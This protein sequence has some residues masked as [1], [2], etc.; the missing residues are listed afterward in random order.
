MGVHAWGRKV[1]SFPPTY[2]GEEGMSLLGTFTVLLRK[3]EKKTQPKR[4]SR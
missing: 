1:T 2:S 3:A 4:P